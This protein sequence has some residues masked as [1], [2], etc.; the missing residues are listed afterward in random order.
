VLKPVARP[1]SV[2][3]KITAYGEYL[4]S[5]KALVDSLAMFKS[6]IDEQ[7]HTYLEQ[8]GK[9]P[10]WRLKAK[11]KMRQWIDEETVHKELRALGFA[12][13]DIFTTKL[14]TFQSIDA[15]AKRKGVKVPDHLR[16]APVTHET[17]IATDNDPAPV[18]EPAKLI[19]KFSAS[20]KLLK[21][22]KTAV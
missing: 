18:V 12:T 16:V 21:Q 10:G 1:A 9:V 7:L 14:Q 5:A 22:E 4:A 3:P 17:T 15:T 19:E 20:L 8:G 2:E 6:T 11:T 13:E